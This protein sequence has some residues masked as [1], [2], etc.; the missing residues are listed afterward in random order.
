M[1]RRVR[2]YFSYTQCTAAVLALETNVK[3]HSSVNKVVK[4]LLVFM[5]SHMSSVSFNRE[6][7]KGQKWSLVGI[8]VVS[9]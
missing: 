2:I 6:F 3:S 5:L 7:D 1:H 9:E 8:G 4:S